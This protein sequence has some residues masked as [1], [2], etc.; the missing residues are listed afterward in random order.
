MKKEQDQKSTTTVVQVERLTAEEERILRM[1][2]G[3]ELAGDAALESKLDGVAEAHRADV[4]ARLRLIEADA[5]LA[6]EGEERADVKRRIVDALKKQAP[7]EQAS[8]QQ[9][10]ADQPSED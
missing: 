4:E 8:A 6:I 5:L 9:A 2:A 3:A 10:S 7:A 1:R